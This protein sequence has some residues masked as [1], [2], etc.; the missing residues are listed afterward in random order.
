MRATDTHTQVQAK[1]DPAG[2]GTYTGEARRYFE[3]CV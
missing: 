1:A 3:V 2:D